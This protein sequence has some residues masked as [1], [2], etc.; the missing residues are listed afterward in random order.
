M[1]VG[2]SEGSSGAGQQQALSKHAPSC[3]VFWMDVG[4]TPEREALLC[5]ILSDSSYCQLVFNLHANC[6]CF[7]ISENQDVKLHYL[8]LRDLSKLQRRT[9]LM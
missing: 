6:Y 3:S 7:S 1:G 5:L 2:F 4:A 9:K 8:A